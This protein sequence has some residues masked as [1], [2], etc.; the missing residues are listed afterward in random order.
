M[1]VLPLQNVEYT[2]SCIE[3]KGLYSPYKLTCDSAL[4]ELQPDP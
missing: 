1:P 3:K 2:L 4:N